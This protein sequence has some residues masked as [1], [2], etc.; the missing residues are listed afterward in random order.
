MQFDR[1]LEAIPGSLRVR[2]SVPDDPWTVI[3]RPLLWS[4][5]AAICATALAA[6]PGSARVASLIL[7]VAWLYLATGTRG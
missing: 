3:R 7:K 6:W 5:I 2:A 4:A 1:R